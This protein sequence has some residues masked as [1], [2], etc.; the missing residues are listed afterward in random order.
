RN[1]DLVRDIGRATA[2]AVRASGLHWTFAPTLAVVQD[3]RWGRT[4]DSFSADPALVR[5]LGQAEVEGLQEGMR[6]GRGV[7]ATAKHYV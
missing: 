1:A 2:R 3:L 4:Y 6:E 7:L 5:Q